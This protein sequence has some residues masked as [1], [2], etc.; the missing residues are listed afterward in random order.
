MQHFGRH[1]PARL[2]VEDEGWTAPWV[3]IGIDD[4]GNEIGMGMLL[5]DIVE[6][7][8]P[9]GA[10]KAARTKADVLIVSAVA[11]WSAFALLAALAIA[12]PDLAAALL[13]HFHG[14]LERVTL[15]SAMELGQAVD[16]SRVDKCR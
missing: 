2:F 10:L 11:N 1:C 4:G 7:D 3:T 9:S 8:L 16:D 13:P 5:A 12:R 14:T 15:R 6:N